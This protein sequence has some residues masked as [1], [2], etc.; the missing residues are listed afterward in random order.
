MFGSRLIKVAALACLCVV[1]SIFL[2]PGWLPGL[3]HAQAS[4][5]GSA[6]VRFAGAAAAA[7]AVAAAAALAGSAAAS[8]TDLAAFGA[9][10][11]D[12]EMEEE[13]LSDEEEVPEDLGT[14]GGSAAAVQV[15]C[16]CST[17]HIVQDNSLHGAKGRQGS[18]CK[19]ASWSDMNG[20]LGRVAVAPA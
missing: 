11:L 3:F 19:R 6:K 15:Q 5:G 12:W 20:S 4:G 9:E 13:D 1:I 8:M 17:V 7:G 16:R 2:L 14:S 18:T 10:A